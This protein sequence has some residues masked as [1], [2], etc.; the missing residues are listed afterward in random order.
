M[1]ETAADLLQAK[2]V[3]REILDD[4]K[5]HQVRKRVEA[6]APPPF[7]QLYRW[8][9]KPPLIPILDL[10]QAHPHNAAGHLA[11]KGLHPTSRKMKTRMF[12]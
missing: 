6:L 8:A 1:V 9:D 11:V 4:L 12:L 3:V 10:P 5:L 2:T 7:S